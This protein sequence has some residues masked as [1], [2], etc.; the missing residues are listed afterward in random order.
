MN[1]YLKML[2]DGQPLLD[3]VAFMKILI[4]SQDDVR[5]KISYVHKSMNYNLKLWHQEWK[6]DEH[7]LHE[8][9]L[10]K[11]R[12][13]ADV[14]N[15]VFEWNG[16][17]IGLPHVVPLAGQKKSYKLVGGDGVNQSGLILLFSTQFDFKD[18]SPDKSYGEPLKANLAEYILTLEGYLRISIAPEGMPES[19]YHLESNWDEYERPISLTSRFYSN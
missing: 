4:K 13:M 7:F 8:P 9:I 15:E 12:A 10:E 5:I 17:D 6:D 14:S 1:D 2:M 18:F 16:S 3:P 11:S 19:F